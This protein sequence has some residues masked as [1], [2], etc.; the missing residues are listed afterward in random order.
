M[1]VLRV[2]LRRFRNPSYRQ[3]FRE[4]RAL[5]FCN[6]PGEGMVKFLVKFLIFLAVFCG[7]IYM[8]INAL[9]DPISNKALAFVFNNL[10]TPSLTLSEPSFKNARISS[11]N[12]VT[13]D[14]FSF[15]A[16]IGTDGPDKKRLKA[17]VKVAELTVES[18]RL[19]DG[20][21]IVDLGGLNITTEYIPSEDSSDKKGA[22]VV[23]QDGYLSA[24]IRLNVLSLSEAASQLRDFAVETRKFSA[25][26]KTA[27]PIKFS[28][29]E[30]ITI[31]DKSY[32]VRLL[33]QQKDGASRLVANKDDLKFV[34]EGVL[35]KTQTSTAADIEIIAH[36]P[37][38][39]PQLLKIRAKASN[40]ASSAYEKDPNV[41]K[42]AYRHVL[43]SYLLTREYGAD[44]AREVADAHE[45]TN[46]PEEKNDPDAEAY[47]RQDYNNNEVGRKY[48][49][50][51]YSESDI[52]LLVKTDPKVI[53]RIK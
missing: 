46:N 26:G 44:F 5:L 30:I 18:E 53:R 33:I 22:M 45:L 16:I 2:A 42:D 29:E 13:W 10:H 40:T 17:R 20:L 43:W 41:P 7:I 24:P 50:A 27:I 39:A 8:M 35:P 49:E 19:F 52:L 25:E 21:F 12:A 23:L 14:E 32:T 36:N 9:L 48:A 4:R 28:G 3:F 34:S 1:Q 6:A 31:H 38:R 47:H 11:Y 51:G 37:I 15:I